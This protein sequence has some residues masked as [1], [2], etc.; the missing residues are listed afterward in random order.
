MARPFTIPTQVVSSERET[1]QGVF[2]DLRNQNWADAAGRLPEGPLR[3]VPLLLKDLGWHVAGEPTGDG[4]AYLHD[5]PRP[6]TSAVAAALQAAGAVRLGRSRVPEP[7]RGASAYSGTW[8]STVGACVK[9]G[10][11][12]AM[13][14]SSGSGTY[15][16]CPSAV[17][18]PVG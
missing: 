15:S 4:T 9:I 11:G 18:G 2:A 13:S 6:V 5:V 3:G 8:Q 1:Y 10:G 12:G 17:R 16:L 14:G 7:D